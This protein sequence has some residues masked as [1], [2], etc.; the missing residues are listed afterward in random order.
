VETKGREYRVVL[1]DGTSAPVQV[2][3]WWPKRAEWPD[4][5]CP[6][7]YH[8]VEGAIRRKRRNMT[9]AMVQ[10]PE[11]LVFG[12][13]ECGTPINGVVSRRMGKNIALGRL[14]KQVNEMGYGMVRA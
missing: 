9:V 6:I 11:G 14:R 7:P 1:K 10:M 2:V 4:G 8:L 12:Y 13:T 5:F 3:R